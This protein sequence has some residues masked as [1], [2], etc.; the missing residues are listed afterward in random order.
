M[1]RN[2]LILVVA[3]FLTSC[4][5]PL[6]LEFRAESEHLK[7]RAVITE[8]EAGFGDGLTKLSGTAAIHNPTSQAQQY[9]NMWL[10]LRSA[11]GIEE[12]AYLNNLTSHR[13]DSGTVKIE[14]GDT[15][16]ISVYWVIPDAEIEQLG[17]GGFI[18]EVHP[19]GD[20]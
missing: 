2:L 15:L 18:L 5:Q 10:L 9:S 19:S 16:E 8:S 1:T 6:D 14:P 3:F 4:A 17:Y 11:R 7:V 13:I 12:R 20:T